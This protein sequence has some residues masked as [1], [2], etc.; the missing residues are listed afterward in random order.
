MK[1]MNSFLNAL[2]AVIIVS[3]ISLIGVLTLALNKKF[4][5]KILTLLVSFSVGALL[6]GAFLHLIP[7]AFGELGISSFVP[8]LILSGIMIFFVLEKFIHWRH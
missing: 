6:G 7:E 1:S 2:I 4:L 5:E 8:L 3:L